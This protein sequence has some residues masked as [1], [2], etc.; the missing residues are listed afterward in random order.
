MRWQLPLGDPFPSPGDGGIFDCWRV[1]WRE[2]VGAA[3]ACN[4]WRSPE[5]PPALSTAARM[6]GWGRPDAA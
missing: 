6:A 3:R 4:L 1:P 5:W 2:L